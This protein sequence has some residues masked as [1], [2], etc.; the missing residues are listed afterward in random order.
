MLAGP[1]YNQSYS[2]FDGSVELR[3]LNTRLTVF[4]E[5]QHVHGE[6]K[7]PIE[8]AADQRPALLGGLDIPLLNPQF[9]HFRSP[10][11]SLKDVANVVRQVGHCLAGGCKTPTTPVKSGPTPTGRF[12]GRHWVPNTSCTFATMPS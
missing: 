3:H 6:D 11:H 9:H 4:A 5:R 8:V 10:L 1:V 7:D 12:T 2:V